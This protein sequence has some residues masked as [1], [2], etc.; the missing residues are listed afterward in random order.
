MPDEYSVRSARNEVEGLAVG[1]KHCIG[2][3]GRHRSDAHL[4]VRNTVEFHIYRFN[5]VFILFVVIFPVFCSLFLS[6]LNLFVIDFALF[7][8][9]LEAVVGILIHEHEEN[10]AHR[11]PRGMIA[12]TVAL[13]CECDGVTVKNPPRRLIEISAIGDIGHPAVFNIDYRNIGVGVVLLIYYLQSNPARVGRPEVIKS[14]VALG[15]CGFGC[16]L[17]HVLALEV[18]YAK[19]RAVE[20]KTEFLS[21]GRNFGHGALMLVGFKHRFLT[22]NCGMGEIGFISRLFES[23]TVDIIKAV[24]VRSIVECG[25]IGPHNFCFSSGSVGYLF[26]SDI[27]D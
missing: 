21:V 8:R 12:H 24:A 23:S 7:F 4:T 22:N 19:V 1:V 16:K 13:R 9:E 10:I 5:L 3:L 18:H 11:A 17:L 6:L 15:M 20:Y 14:S 25:I 26:G 27:V 2:E